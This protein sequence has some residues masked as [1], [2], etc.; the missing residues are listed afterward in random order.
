MGRPV[1]LLTRNML[2]PA[3]V[4]RPTGG[5]LFRVVAAIAALLIET[6]SSKASSFSPG[7]Q[8][9][10]PY[11]TEVLRAVHF[12]TCVHSSR[13][14]LAWCGLRM[15]WPMSRSLGD[16]LPRAQLTCADGAAFLDATSGAS[17][18]VAGSRQVAGISFAVFRPLLTNH[19]FHRFC[20]SLFYAYCVGSGNILGTGEGTFWIRITHESNLSASATRRGRGSARWNGC[21]LPLL[22]EDCEWSLAS[23][24]GGCICW[25]V[26]HT[27]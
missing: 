23:A 27:P 19:V 18:R 22:R 26:A 2:Q 25:P 10:R 17:R 9:T 15:P 4:W 1:I 6:A 13:R 16:G 21:A 5:D 7:Q 24:A 20:A 12:Y 8:S 11:Q 3:R 14:T